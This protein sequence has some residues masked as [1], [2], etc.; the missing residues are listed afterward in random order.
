MLDQKL[1]IWLTLLA[2]ILFG[3]AS[4]VCN[5]SVDV[6]DSTR[7]PL[8]NTGP[9]PAIRFRTVRST[10]SPSSAIQRRCHAPQPNS[11]AATSTLNQRLIREVMS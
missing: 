2:L 3:V 10:M 6:F 5:H 4:D 8:L 11:A 9:L 7:S 1:A